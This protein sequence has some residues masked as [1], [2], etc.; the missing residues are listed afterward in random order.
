MSRR[1]A[2]VYDDALSGHVPR[3]GHAMA[4]TRVRHTYG[5]LEA[6][7]AFQLPNAVLMVTTRR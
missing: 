3:E 1:A 6:Y 4:P 2:F 7:D 5:L